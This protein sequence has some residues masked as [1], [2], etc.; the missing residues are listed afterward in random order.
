MGFNMA[1]APVVDVNTNPSNPVIGPRS[2]GYVLALIVELYSTKELLL[3]HGIA[4]A[5]DA[6]LLSS[7]FT[8]G[9]SRASMA[10]AAGFASAGVSRCTCNIEAA[11]MTVY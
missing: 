9:V 7:S 10:T 11:R 6:P 4:L 1:F 3:F 8:E 5:A 2:Y